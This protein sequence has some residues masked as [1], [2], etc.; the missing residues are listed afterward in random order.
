MTR[1]AAPPRRRAAPPLFSKRVR[2]IGVS[3]TVATAARAAELR[4]QGRDILD[5]SVGEPDQPTPNHIRR[6]AQA[7]MDRGE[8]RYVAS[9]GLP[10][11]RAAIAARYLEDFGARFEPAE[12]AVTLGGKQAYALACEAVLDPGDEV[13]IPSPYWPTF[14][15]APRILG[16]TP[17]FAPLDPRRG[18]AFDPR[19][20]LR[21]VGPR[22]RAVVINT[23]SNPTGAVISEDALL[24]IARSLARTPRTYLIYDDTYARLEFG[25]RVRAL[26]RV[27]SLLG[28]RLLIAGTASK[29]YC[30]TGW[31]IGWLLGAPA[32]IRGVAALISHETQ[33]ATSFAQFGAIEALSGP[34]GLVD[35]L[36][37]EYRGRRDLVTAALRSIPGIAC[38]EPQGAFY[39]FFDVR[40]LAPGRNNSLTFC[41]GLLEQEGVAL[42]AGEGFGRPGFA[43]LSFARSRDELREGLRR[44]I[45]YVEGPG[46][47]RR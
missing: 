12:V 33:C 30:M 17:V 8:T 41:A 9:L 22:T 42:V 1:N 2:S 47:S 35:D 6:A 20:I 11:L 38:H 28:E 36:V 34:Q 16:A 26:G 37:A 39:A 3:P 14:A 32:L 10:A 43:R 45:G 25:E 7:A 29:T 5:F 15:E 18:F 23:P 24:E 31:R 40:K 13:V 46:R 21:R 4:A 27:R 19:R 44:L